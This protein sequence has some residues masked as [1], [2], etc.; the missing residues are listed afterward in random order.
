M[1]QP[2]NKWA[3][4]Q[5]NDCL[6]GADAEIDKLREWILDEPEIDFKHYQEVITA[7]SLIVA[8]LAY[9]RGLR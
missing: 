6:Y 1:S 4:A 5:L 9:V 8:A 7:H 3:I 2:E